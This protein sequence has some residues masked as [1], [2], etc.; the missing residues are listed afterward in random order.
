MGFTTIVT[1]GPSILE[2]EKLV[3]I[4]S[5]GKCIYRINGAHVGRSDLTGVV[6]NIRA[7]LPNASIMLDLPGN[8]VRI[9]RLAEPIPLSKGTSFYLYEDQVNYAPFLKMLQRSDTILANDSI[10]LLEVVETGG[11]RVR[12]RSHSDGV[13]LPGK[14]LHAQ[15]VYAQLPFLFDKDRELIE[16]ACETGLSYLS[17]SYVRDARDIQQAKELI[18]GEVPIISKIETLAAVKNLNA[19]LAEV[20]MINIDRGD[21]SSDIGM[22]NLP[23]MQR[24]II[25]E[26]K[27]AGKQVFLATQVLHNM[28]QYPVP[29]ISEIIDLER[30]INSGIDG[31]QLSGETAV[32]KYPI[33]CVKLIFSLYNNSRKETL[34]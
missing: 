15:R 21:L 1:V 6:E 16:L 26:A 8:K 4:N 32:G 17:L 27:N 34:V 14:G 3:A 33:E 22:L 7:V 28:E 20:D 29:T 12:L 13:L 19:I 5:F 24:Q 23:A 11:K 18:N 30:Y 2:E 10:F 9:N 31:V 25:R